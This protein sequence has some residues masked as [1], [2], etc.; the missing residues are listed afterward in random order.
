MNVREWVWNALCEVIRKETYSNLYLKEHLQEVDEKDRALA[1]NIF[2]GTLQNYALCQ[3]AWKRFAKGKVK[4]KTSILLSMSVYQILFLD[5]IPDF[6]VVNEANKIAARRLPAERGLV[7]AIL[8]KVISTPMEYPENPVE[9][10]ALKTS[11]PSWLIQMWI[12]Q[13]GAQ[14]A[15]RF[16]QASLAALPIVV[17][18]NPMKITP[19]Q[20]EATGRLEPYENG[21]YRYTGSQIATDPLYR[22]G[23]ISVQDPGSCE[24]A[25]WADPKAG[26]KILDL[27][28]A[29]GTKS[30]AM[31]EMAKDLAEITSI[32]LHEHR[33]KLIEKDAK[34]LSLKSVSARAA[35]STKL[36]DDPVYDIVLCDVP[37]SG[38]GVLS[39]KPDMKLRLS[40]ND[41]DALP[42]LQYELLESGSRQLKNGGI[43]IYSTCTLNKKE[44]EKQVESFLSAHDEF[45]LLDQKTIEP[46]D[47]HGGFFLA[48]LQK[49]KPAASRKA[50]ENASP[51]SPQP[52]TET[53]AAAEETIARA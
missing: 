14:S 18:L 26:M 23:K 24:I 48:K 27:C 51:E 42:P 10:L 53:S 7:N 47:R 29:P 21:L 37:C 50:E 11:L 31:A 17:R 25:R 8:R 44:N 30:M 52:K 33:A 28:A 2:Y 15:F 46:D 1:S 38:L 20:A 22:Q 4:P 12:A 45:V 40:S 41:L 5:R 32:D 16:A 39:R 49:V 19:E 13:Y 35:D 6:A 34:R 43:L 9:M 3:A 36:E